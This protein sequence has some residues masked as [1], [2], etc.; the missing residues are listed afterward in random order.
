MIKFLNKHTQKMSAAMVTGMVMGSMG[1]VLA[2]GGTGDNFN[3]YTSGLSSQ[4]TGMPNVVS[5]ISY[6]G[7]FALA[8]LGVVGL[9]NHVE[10]PAN[11]PMKNGLAKLGFGGMLMALPSVV[12]AIQGSGEA[13]GGT[14]VEFNNFTTTGIGR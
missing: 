11:E 1:Q 9:K 4:V 14:S 3:S 7:G 8:A 2:A 12:A 10:N 6:L 13:A 5:Y